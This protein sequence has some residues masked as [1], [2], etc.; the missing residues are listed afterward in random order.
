MKKNITEEEAKIDNN[1]NVDIDSDVTGQYLREHL[2][3]KDDPA[4][5][6]DI[7]MFFEN[8]FLFQVNLKLLF[9]H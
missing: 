1:I 7:D 2:L 8:D 9:Y 6:A 4:V 5:K 3:I